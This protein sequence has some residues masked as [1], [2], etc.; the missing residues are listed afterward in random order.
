LIFAVT[1]QPVAAAS[2]VTRAHGEPASIIT[3]GVGQANDYRTVI[4]GRVRDL[5]VRDGTVKIL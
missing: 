4:A 5:G 1:I 2:L 3:E